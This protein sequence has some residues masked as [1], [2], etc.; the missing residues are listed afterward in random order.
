MP[1][2]DNLARLDSGQWMPYA[3][4]LAGRAPAVAGVLTEAEIRATGES[5]AAAQEA[6][7]ATGWPGGRLE[8]RRVR[9]GAVSVRAGWSGPA[10]LR[11]AAGDPAGRRLLAA[12][13][14]A[15]RRGERGRG[16]EQ[17]RRLRGRGCLAR[18]SGYRGRRVRGPD[19]AHGAPGD[20]VRHRH[21]D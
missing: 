8:P 3:R 14:R 5:I 17:P 15:R 9:H 7:G 4:S 10:G 19:V 21:A 13:Y 2:G 18:V 12:A 16:R 20:R 1:V 11:V 6:S